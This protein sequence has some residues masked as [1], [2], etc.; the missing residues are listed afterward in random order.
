MNVIK[1]SRV[2]CLTSQPFTAKA[3]LL[4]HNNHYRYNYDYCALFQLLTGAFHRI[5]RREVD[6]QDAQQTALELRRGKGGHLQE[7]VERLQ[8]PACHH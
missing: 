3:I 8:L 1:L 7:I 6:H 4:R 5:A 2:A